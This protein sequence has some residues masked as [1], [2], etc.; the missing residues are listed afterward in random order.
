[1]RST[2]AALSAALLL[3]APAFGNDP[4]CPK[5]LSGAPF[6]DYERLQVVAQAGQEKAEKDDS[7]T[8]NP[9]LSGGGGQTGGNEAGKSEKPPLEV[10]AEEEMAAVRFNTETAV[11]P[12]V[13]AG[14]AE[15]KEATVPGASHPDPAREEELTP[16][17]GAGIGCDLG[18][19]T[20]LNLGYRYSNSALSP[21]GILTDPKSADP[22]ATSDGYDLSFGL[23]IGF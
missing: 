4:T 12:Y 7:Y 8:L 9:S 15:P 16:F 21:P 2:L 23:K 3:A 14:L 1:M 19:S 10:S 6:L 5:P 13:G 22:A 18:N 17:L 11:T 20:R